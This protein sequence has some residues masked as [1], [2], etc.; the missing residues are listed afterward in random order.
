MDKSLAVGLV[1]EEYENASKHYPPFTS[2]HEGCSVIR[3]EFEELWDEVKKKKEQ[4]D[5]EKLTKEIKQVG[6]MAIRFMVNL[7]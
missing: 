3:E 2:H 1:L 7:L 6:A 4:R 5:K